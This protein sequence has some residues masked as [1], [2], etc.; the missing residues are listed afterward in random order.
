M[1]IIHYWKGEMIHII[2]TNT[3]PT[4]CL[5]KEKIAL[6]Y[7]LSFD[8]KHEDCQE[9]QEDL[10]T[11]LAWSKIWLLRFNKTKCTVLRIRKCFEFIYYLNGIPSIEE[12]NQRDLGVIISNDLHPDF[13]ISHIV[14][15]ANQRIGLIR[16]CF[17]NLT[18]EKVS[19]LYISIVRPI[20]EYGSTVWSSYLAKVQRRCTRISNHPFH[21]EPLELCK[22]SQNMCEVYKYLHH[23]YKTNTDKLFKLST[24][25]SYNTRTQL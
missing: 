2:S 9:I 15:K 18:S 23:S 22:R 14:K 4:K 17:T 6:L 25:I 21:I 7:I 24:S 16:R 8:T 20:L 13:H 12:D 10:N 19:I 5:H 11:L 3:L 1:I